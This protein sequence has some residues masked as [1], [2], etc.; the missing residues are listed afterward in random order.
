M[1]KNKVNL[2]VPIEKVRVGVI[3]AVLCCFALIVILTSSCALLPHQAELDAARYTSGNQFII[4]MT[5]KAKGMCERGE[6]KEAQCEEIKFHY[7]QLVEV[8]HRTADLLILKI[9]HAD[10]IDEVHVDR[11]FKIASNQLRVAQMNYIILL[12]RHG[13]IQEQDIR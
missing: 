10:T 1:S 3:L 4:E 7:G 8:D 9:K 12:A 13:V 5:K 2:L 11:D 6:L